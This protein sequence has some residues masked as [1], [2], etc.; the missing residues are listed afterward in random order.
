MK[1]G[2]YKAKKVGGDTFTT[3]NGKPQIWIEFETAEGRIRWFLS[4]SE[5]KKFLDRDGKDTTTK[6]E[7]IKKLAMLG[8]D[9]KNKCAGL[10]S[11]SA[12]EF[13]ICVENEVYEGKTRAKIKWV[14]DGSGPPALKPIDNKDAFFA[15]LASA[16]PDEEIPF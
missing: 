11:A 8:V 3:S 16:A 14:N 9:V 12:K 5:D 10:S 15:S 4:F 1:P 7:S 2:I 13:T 6:I